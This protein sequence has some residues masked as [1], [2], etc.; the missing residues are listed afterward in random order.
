MADAE[1]ENIARTSEPQA[2]EQ[3]AQQ[4]RR[5]STR[6]K[7]L[8]RLGLLVLVV[9]LLWGAWYLLF[10]RNHVS[11]DNA[12]VNA[13]M[14]QVTPLIGAQAIDVLVSDTQSVKKGD[15]LVKLDPTNAQIAVAQAEA[16]LAEARRRFRQTDATSD[17]LAAQVQARSAD[18]VQAR[19]QLTTAQ[20]DLEKARVDLQRREALVA[21]GAVSGDEVTAAQTAYASARAALRLA[22]AGVKTAEATRGAAT[23]Q[24]EANQ[25]LVRGSTEDTDPAVLAA[26]A[27]LESAKL[28]LER[29]TI[30]A[31]ID[32]VVTKRQVQ[33]GQRVA[34]G[35]PIMSIVPISQVYVDA[36]FKE[37]QLRG[38]RIGM[39]AKV[40]SDLYGGD[41]VYHGKIVGF[42]GGTGSS[43]ALIPAQNATGN[44][45][46]VVQRLPLRIALDPKELAAHPLR[47]GLS[48]E[49]EIDLAD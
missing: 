12:Y 34:Q 10:G 30:R 27:R 23:G 14:A 44:W 7:W 1:P 38:V 33:V 9:A 46:K 28:D 13:E 48:M 29:T 49:V 6:R 24:L 37:K 19:A 11:T 3:D 8:I 43:M 35:S 16:D 39:P 18:I 2:S 4:A 20:A 36:N 17:S 32:G 42:S 15:I 21:D 31:P 26:K 22:Q 25:A 47:V 40:T 5:N 45:I 41:V